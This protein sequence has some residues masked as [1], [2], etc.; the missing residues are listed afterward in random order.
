MVS[1]IVIGMLGL[2]G[3]VALLLVALWNLPDLSVACP[4][5]LAQAS[6]GVPL[7]LCTRLWPMAT[8]ELSRAPVLEEAQLLLQE[9][10]D[11][12]ASKI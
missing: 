5:A 7:K 12:S 6:R 4:S 2:G 3:H 11:L 8:M 1:L 10:S 9:L